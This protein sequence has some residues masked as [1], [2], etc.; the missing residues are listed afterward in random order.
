MNKFTKI[1]IFSSLPF[2]TTSCGI[3]NNLLNFKK[4]KGIYV[5]LRTSENV[6]MSLDSLTF[7]NEFNSSSVSEKASCDGLNPSFVTSETNHPKAETELNPNN[8]FRHPIYQISSYDNWGNI[9]GSSHLSFDLYLRVLG[10]D[11]GET[12]LLAKEIYFSDFSINISRGKTT[13]IETI[14]NSLRIQ[15][16]QLNCDTKSLLLSEKGSSIKLGGPL[17]LNNDGNND[18]A[19]DYEWTEKT[20]LTYGDPSITQVS[21]PYS[22]YIY[23]ESEGGSK[24][25][26]QTNEL[27]TLHFKVTIWLEGWA[28]GFSSSIKD[29]PAINIGMA[30][31][32]QPY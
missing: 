4:K 28:N 32:S 21:A 8:D 27:E 31:M 13:E 2:L 29:I 19:V 9:S 20:T 11:G 22:N 16:D 14:R 7:Q 18:D 1:I 3:V 25:L 15:F 26:C 24:P 6:Q 17:D 12:D 10:L 23:S 30:L 5:S